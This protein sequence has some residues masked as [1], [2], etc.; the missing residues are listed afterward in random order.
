MTGINRPQQAKTTVNCIGLK[1]MSLFT[2]IST[3]NTRRK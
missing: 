3:S 1:Y 2:K